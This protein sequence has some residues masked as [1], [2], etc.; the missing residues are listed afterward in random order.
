MN[1]SEAMTRIRKNVWLSQVNEYEP[2]AF[3]QL[4]DQALAHPIGVDRWPCY[5]RLKH[6][7]SKIVGWEATH[8][9]LATNNHY[10]TVVGFIDEMLPVA[11]EHD[12]ADSF[13]HREDSDD[14]GLTTLGDWMERAWL[15]GQGQIS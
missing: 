2:L 14:G 3:R 15:R 8:Q 10:E 11:S 7:A 5:E 9:E 4:V 13:L 1:K 6:Q 12:V